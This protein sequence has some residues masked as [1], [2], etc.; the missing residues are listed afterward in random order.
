MEITVNLS[1]GTTRHFHNAA[2]DFTE[3]ASDGF[4]DISK[5]FLIVISDGETNKIPCEVIDSF[6]FRLG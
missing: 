1:N 6:S 3:K 2:F 5:G 4:I